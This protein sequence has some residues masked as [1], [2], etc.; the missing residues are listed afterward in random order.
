M[1][2]KHIVYPEDY[3]YEKTN[4]S[5]NTTGEDVEDGDKKDDAT[6]KYVVAM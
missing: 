1:N 3:T 6:N 2:T 5:K 4:T